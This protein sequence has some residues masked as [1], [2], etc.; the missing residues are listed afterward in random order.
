M[1]INTATIIIIIIITII[2]IFYFLN[3]IIIEDF[4]V[5]KRLPVAVTWT[6]YIV[7]YINQPAYSNYF[8]NNGYM[9]PVY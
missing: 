4:Y 2:I 7:D 9:Y 6:P 1:L 5:R 3:K 8:Y